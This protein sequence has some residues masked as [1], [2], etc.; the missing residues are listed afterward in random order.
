MRSG[1]RWAP[2]ALLQTTNL[3]S[4]VSNGVVTIAIPWL[5]LQRTGSVTAAGLIAA[6]SALPGIIASPLAGW[7]VDHFGRRIVSIVSDV[8]SAIS[9]AAIPLMAMVTDLNL[10]IILALAMLGAVF[11][12]L[13][14]EGVQSLAERTGWSDQIANNLPDLLYGLLVV[15]V[16]LVLP[17]GLVGSVL[18]KRRSQ[19]G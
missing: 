5:V 3:L 10:A 18:A 14:P 9:V 8:L 4:G 17:G 11:I 15:V 7:A 12:V 16:V 19:A 13:L 1:I 6:M 2:I